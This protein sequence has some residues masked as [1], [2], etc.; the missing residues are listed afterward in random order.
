M[1][2]TFSLR[3]RGFSLIEVAIAL[4]IFVIGA[5]A[6]IRIFPGALNVINN[7]GDQL[8][9]TNISRSTVAALQSDKA[10]PDATFNLGRDAS[11]NLIWTTS[12]SANHSTDWKDSDTSVL[13]VPRFNIS[14]PDNGTTA[15]T[16]T[17][18]ALAK[19]R[20]VV[21]EPEDSFTNGTDRYA[22][23]QFPISVAPQGAPAV[24]APLQ[25]TISQDY[26]V[27]NA[28]VNSDGT[29]DFSQIKNI[30][31]DPSNAATVVPNANA[32]AAGS[33][34][35]VS[36]RY[37]NAAGKTWGIQQ[38]AIPVTTGFADLKAAPAGT[39]RVNPPSTGLG[40][41]APN[42]VVAEVV[43]VRLRNYRG[44]GTFG[45][46][47]A[48]ASPVDQAAAAVADARLGFVR[49]TALPGFD[50]LNS[51]VV[52]DYVADWS[53]LL[54]DALPQVTPGALA[55]TAPTTLPNNESYRQVA[56]GAPFI[57]D[58]I[59]AGIYSL[60]IAPDPTTPNQDAIYRS[61]F[62]TAYPAPD[63]AANK[64]APPTEDDLRFGRVT[65]AV[66]DNVKRVRVAYQTR[67]SWAEQLS[68]AA[69][70][71]KPYVPPAATTVTTSIE[72]WRDY[73]LDTGG[74][75]YFHAGEAGKSITVSYKFN[76]STGEQVVVARPFV[77]SD[78]LVGPPGIVPASFFSNPPGQAAAPPKVSRVLLTDSAGNAI[79][80]TSIQAVR[81]T[82]VTVRTAY[83][84]GARYA[85][86]PITTN[87]SRSLTQ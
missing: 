36:Y 78:E 10:V 51:S 72:P 31:T 58:Q 66:A 41:S 4:V 42:E 34:L 17:N 20:V 21:G 28:R 33:L 32:V 57:E 12:T 15:A 27:Q 67:D 47:P 59:P 73:V 81:G 62:G 40:A 19:Y 83:M 82:S 8:V 56:L 22:F 80:P 16:D 77:I 6:I 46:T 65:L 86:V 29:L 53:F 23:T 44:T 39:F 45:P 38:E 76:A 84:N 26:D 61:A 79:T 68:V 3:K 37:K 48:L 71:Y 74:S 55:P 18:S 24:L 30:M 11:G 49:L 2:S 75:L 35:Y 54:K 70:A 9:A 87:V 25:P 43:D 60:V 13:G 50:T 52:I 14:L 7:N 5:L 1:T 85:Q 64:L 69:M 63:A